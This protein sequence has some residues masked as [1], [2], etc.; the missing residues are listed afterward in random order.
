MLYVYIGDACDMDDDNDGVLDER[1]NCPKVKNYEQTDTNGTPKCTIHAVHAMLECTVFCSKVRVM[2]L[3]TL[4]TGNG[5]G[6]AC[7]DDCDGDGILDS[8]DAAPCNRFLT[9]DS[10]EQF[11][12]VKL[13]NPVQKEADWV[14]QKSGTHVVQKASSDPELLVGKFCTVCICTCMLSPALCCHGS[15]THIYCYPPTRS[16]CLLII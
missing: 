9:K 15:L 14:V 12:S 16:P 3:F 5:I 1:D 10:L 2:A 8:V 7:E 4:C 13:S 11:M 6:D